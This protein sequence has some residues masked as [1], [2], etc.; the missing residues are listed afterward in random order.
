[1]LN[2]IIIY[3]ISF[4]LIIRFNP[5]TSKKIKDTKENREFEREIAYSAGIFLIL[6]TGAVK[7]AKH[8]INTFI[9]SGA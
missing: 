3:Y 4:F 2:D 1:M 7:L 9:D 5:W 6:S 8:Y